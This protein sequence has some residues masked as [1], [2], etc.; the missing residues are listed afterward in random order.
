MKNE[1]MREVP[2]ERWG[3]VLLEEVLFRAAEA[4]S[5]KRADESSVDVVLTLR[6]TANVAEDCFEIRT[7]AGAEPAL[8][9]R[10]ARPF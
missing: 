1:P 7:D 5:A 9:T 3:R 8:V 4:V 6:L 2:I 10:L